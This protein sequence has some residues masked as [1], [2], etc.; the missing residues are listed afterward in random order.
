MA[1]FMRLPFWVTIDLLSM[2]AFPTPSA[3]GV[4]QGWCS[5]ISSWTWVLFLCTCSQ[6]LFKITN[7]MSLLRYISWLPS[8]DSTAAFEAQDISRFVSRSSPLTS[9]FS[10]QNIQGNLKG[11]R[12]YTPVSVLFTERW[13]DHCIACLSS[14]LNPYGDQLL[15]QALTL[16]N[17]QPNGK[18]TWRIYKSY[19]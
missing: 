1:M 19:R 4:F 17:P 7:H 14:S 16:S 3:S 8:R 6:E 18:T 2:R 11:Q 5:M 9:L 13:K 15:N 12:C 10:Y